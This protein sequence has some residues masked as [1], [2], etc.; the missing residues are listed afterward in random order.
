MLPTADQLTGL[1][2]TNKHYNKECIVSVMPNL[3]YVILSMLGTNVD[4]ADKGAT[5]GSH[6]NLCL[7]QQ[8]K[9]YSIE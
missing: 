6:L 3:I 7:W 1:L 2:Y 5:T 4:N 9:W 8:H